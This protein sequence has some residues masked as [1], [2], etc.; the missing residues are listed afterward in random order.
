MFP[1]N[2][3]SEIDVKEHIVLKK[4]EGDPE[5]GVLLE[6]VI[7]EDGEIIEVIKEE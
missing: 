6:T 4:F 3:N 1:L 5:D 2:E 7:I